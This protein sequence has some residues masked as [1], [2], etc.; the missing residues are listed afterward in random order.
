MQKR[1]TGGVEQY[2]R[3]ENKHK[4]QGMY[5]IYLSYV[6]IQ[7]VYSQADCWARLQ[8]VLGC[9]TLYI[10]MCHACGDV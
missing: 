5:V 10:C 9:E 4:S 7:G 8:C 6:Y 3:E 1:D 2:N